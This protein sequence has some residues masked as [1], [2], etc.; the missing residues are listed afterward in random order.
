MRKIYGF[1]F[2]FLFFSFKLKLTSYLEIHIRIRKIR[3]RECIL[4]DFAFKRITYLCKII[5]K[6][7]LFNGNHKVLMLVFTFTYVT[8]QKQLNR[9]IL[10]HQ[11]CLV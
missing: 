7:F 11:N 4:M 3:R 10:K 8:M 5:K 1:V 2:F 9:A 6:N